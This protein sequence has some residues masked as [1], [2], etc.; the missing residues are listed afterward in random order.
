MKTI[1]PCRNNHTGMHPGQPVPLTF[2]SQLLNYLHGFF[3]KVSPQHE[4]LDP[5]PVHS[6]RQRIHQIEE[7]KIVSLI[8][9]SILILFLEN[10]KEL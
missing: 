1:V 2:F 6:V 9:C 10:G 7:T 8:C 3:G 4:I 5:P